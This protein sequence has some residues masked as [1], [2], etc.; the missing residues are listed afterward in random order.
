[1]KLPRRKFITSGLL[2]TG[3]AVAANAFWIEKYFIETNEFFIG[4][5]TKNT[6]NIRVVQ[7]SDLHLQSLSP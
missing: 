3:C 5:A 2:L 4:T 1:M 6:N 7:I